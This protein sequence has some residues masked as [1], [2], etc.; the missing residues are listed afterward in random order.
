MGCDNKLQAPCMLLFATQKIHSYYHKYIGVMC[1]YVIT[2]PHGPTSYYKENITT[3]ICS[4]QKESTA[5][6][7]LANK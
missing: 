1:M 6:I 4:Q 7:L 2:A 3:S 5:K